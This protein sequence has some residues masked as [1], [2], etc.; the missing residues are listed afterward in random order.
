ME[1]N[2][3]L[4]ILLLLTI[5]VLIIYLYNQDKNL[6]YFDVS[7]ANAKT[8]PKTNATPKMIPQVIS[9][10][11]NL[12]ADD[13]HFVIDST[14]SLI[15]TSLF[16]YK[17]NKYNIPNLSNS[18]PNHPEQSLHEYAYLSVFRHKAFTSNYNPLGQYAHISTEPL[19]LD[20]AM[21]TVIT[22]KSIS[23]LTSSTIL[24]ISYTLI[25]SSDKNLDGEMF[26]VWHPNAPHGS[27]AMGD[28]IVSGIEAPPLEYVRC[29]PITMLTPINISNGIIWQAAND[30]NKKC[31]CWGASNIDLFRA[32]NEYGGDI[33]ELA[34]VYNLPQQFL[35]NNTLLAESTDIKKGVQI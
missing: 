16:N 15:E 24:P 2:I 12:P 9:L 27:I 29:L 22:K 6:E 3:V 4:A 17:L 34:S 25:W 14:P 28:I 23:T 10:N 20:D 26:S 18:N 21:N 8:N 32:S 7:N 33:P 1:N 31:I 19:E 35:Q 5:I 30:M 13:I 11:T